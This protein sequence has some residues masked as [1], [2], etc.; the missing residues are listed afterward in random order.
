MKSAINDR[1]NKEPSRS[2]T[3]EERGNLILPAR[4]IFDQASMDATLNE[5][6]VDSSQSNLRRLVLKELAERLKV[7]RAAIRNTCIREFKIKP[8]AAL[9]A[10]RSYSY[11]TDRV[12]STVLDLATGP[13]C[14]V[15]ELNTPISVLA[16]G[17]YGRG[18]MA[19]H[20]D[21]DL[22][23]LS[24]DLRSESI[25]KTIEA[26]L[27]L[28]WDLKL[29]VGY[30]VRTID[31]CLSFAASDMTVRTAL[32]ES[33]R[34]WGSEELADKLADR[35]W[36]ELYKGTGPQFVEAKLAERE[37][38][39]KKQGGNRYVVEPNVKEGKGGLRDIQTLFWIIKYLYRVDSAI[40]MMELD[41]FS[42]EEYEKFISAESFLWSV[43]C[44]LH[45]L[46][47]R[48][49]EILHFD[50]Q[51]DIANALGYFDTKGRRAVEFFMQ[52]Y[53]RFA[54]DVGELTRIFLT[55][56]EEQHVKRQPRL[57]SW[58]K[59]ARLRFSVQL[60]DEF[61][62]LQ[63]RLSVRNPDEFIKD[64]LNILRLFETALDTELLLHPD[65]MRLVS[66]NLHLVDE[67]FRNDPGA[68]KI[69]LDLLLNHGNPER[70]LRRMNELGLLGAFI[71][72]FGHIVAMMQYNNY[73]HYTVDEHTI[74]CITVLANVERGD[75]VEELP[76][77]S[78][79][80]KQGVNRRVLYVAL[81]LHDIGKGRN[82]D[83]SIV[84]AEIASQLAPRFGLDEHE[85]ELVVWLVRHHLTMSDVAQKRDVH[86]PRTIRN[87]A[88]LV[89][90]RTR[91]KL[92]TVLTVC[93]I[94]G[95]GPN[96]WNNWKAQMLRDLYHLTHAALTEGLAS[97]A[98][99]L[100]VDEARDRFAEQM[101]DWSDQRAKMELDRYYPD[102][103]RGLSTNTHVTFAEL[104]GQFGDDP[105][106]VRFV[107]DDMRSANQVC[108]AMRDSRTVFAKLAGMLLLANANIVDAKCFTTKDGYLT[109]AFWLQD[110]AGKDYEES[111]LTRIKEQI[112]KFM[113]DPDL[114]EKRLAEPGAISVGRRFK[115]DW[116]MFDVPTEIT[117]D[118]EGSDYYTIIEVDTRDRPGL[119]YD[120][121][122]TL[123]EAQV[124]IFS[125]VIATY[126]AQAVDVFYVKDKSGL[127]LLAEARC[128]SIEARLRAAIELKPDSQ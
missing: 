112:L 18:A 99:Q 113:A 102:Y 96:V 70:A 8:Y 101:A 3:E 98:I 97:L 79:I 12:V 37:A 45:S 40:D 77:V 52:D 121:S 116:A 69:F 51:F 15:P 38:R 62:E 81:L 59:Q 108:I 110:F 36:N 90:N 82:A 7:G 9:S 53:F 88:T 71:P 118:N 76:V 27:Y 63:G 60:P 89:E 44:E 115:K 114:L 2:E 126:G 49:Q 61:V 26:I 64:P 84:G 33:R 34:F 41:Y 28:L 92:L 93:D 4:E 124:V 58:I 24:T 119:V 72:E 14:P 42:I 86:R 87:F 20:S 56:L 128:R 91:L 106:K 23:F 11:L 67:Q 25:G 107:Y 47:D 75:A 123:A 54:T 104:L 125:A 78:N 68:N 122:N 30:S 103:W 21:V 35:L 29:K 22:L 10:I 55:K 120:L 1:T 83:H 111:Q 43:R 50:A 6:A 94:I 100:S 48:P 32:L 16:V 127:K 66:A 73:H 117:F 109:A 57:V 65:A 17:G 19:P 105:G 39:Y 74:Q 80:V 85:S 95:V 5:L 46:A 13:L 31:D